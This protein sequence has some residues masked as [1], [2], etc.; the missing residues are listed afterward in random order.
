MDI[1]P[2]PDGGRLSS[3][4]DIAIA[5]L[6]RFEKAFS[7]IPLFAK[8]KSWELRASLIEGALLQHKL[9]QARLDVFPRLNMDDDTYLDYIPFAWTTCN[10]LNAFCMSTQHLYDM[11]VVSVLNFQANVFMKE[12]TQQLVTVF[13]KHLINE[14]FN[15]QLQVENQNGDGIMDHISEAANDNFHGKYSTAQDTSAEKQRLCKDLI[16][17][18]HSLADRQKNAQAQSSHE[19]ATEL[20]LAR[21]A[22][23]R[24]IRN[25]LNHPV[26]EKASTYDQSI[27]KSELKS[28]LLAHVDQGQDLKNFSK[29]QSSTNVIT[30]FTRADLSFYNSVRTTS[31]NH[32]S[33]PYSSAFMSCALGQNGLDSF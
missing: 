21:A 29:Q 32:P 31:A 30:P 27:L 16:S 9:R 3:I 15:L 25:I 4:I 6:E 26:R 20:D 11:M 2:I 8:L 33:Y 1:P 10:N 17:D 18:I 12:V 22:L 5:K 7:K 13:L 28:F 24:Y 14:I 19:I 23:T